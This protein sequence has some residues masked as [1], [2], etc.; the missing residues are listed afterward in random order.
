MVSFPMKTLIKNFFLMAYADIFNKRHYDMVGVGS[1]SRQLLIY[2]YDDNYDIYKQKFSY[3]FDNKIFSII[4]CDLE[5][6]GNTGLIISFKTEENYFENILLDFKKEKGNLNVD[7]IDLENTISAPFLFTNWE[8]AKPAVFLDTS[9][10]IK[11]LCMNDGTI[12]YEILK[13]L[14]NEDERL[15]NDHA[16]TFVDLTGNLQS[17]LCLFV[18]KNGSTW[19]KVFE[20]KPNGFNLLFEIELTNN[21]IGPVLFGD[22]TNS[23]MN[24][25]IFVEDD[26]NGP[27]LNL[28]INKGRRENPIHY[29][30]LK[31]SLEAINIEKGL[32]SKDSLYH[33][34]IPINSLYP[35][36]QAIY[37]LEEL[38]NISGGI[39]VTDIDLDGT[40]E[41]F[42]LIKNEH[43]KKIILPLKFNNTLN[44]FIIYD[45]I[46]AYLRVEDVVISFSTVDYRNKGKE[47]IILNIIEN[48]SPI[49]I[50][51]EN[52]LNKANMKLSLTTSLINKG[53]NKY[54]MSLPGISYMLIFND[55]N[56][57]KISTN[58][59]SGPFLHLVSQTSTIGLGDSAFMINILRI[60]ISEHNK[61]KD[62]YFI[63][64]SIIQ[65]FDLIIFLGEYG[66]YKIVAFFNTSEYTFKILIVLITVI[67]VNLLF[68]LI[69]YWRQSKHQKI[70]RSKDS[71]HPLFRSL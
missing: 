24:S 54:G 63:D 19:L 4:P 40:P 58:F 13:N 17:D 15:K 37:N 2:A 51:Y 68:L 70:I 66:K 36:A 60:G 69:L 32:F 71:T 67:S 38:N 25:M 59:G 50:A 41:I 27:I 10:N 30:S 49:I 35:K 45:E 48:G 33:K 42:L 9:K 12:S 21:K 53:S 11:M 65:N 3:N 1:D 56:N 34:K 44:D 5:S 47:D 52:T 29:K 64:N 8:N 55:G 6:N 62:I 23:G 43:S 46:N 22:F 16:S 31:V 28:Y 26:P 39:Y 57:L 20:S 18:N 7:I 61:H 14:I